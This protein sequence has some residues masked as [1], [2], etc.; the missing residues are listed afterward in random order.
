MYASD[1]PHGEGWFPESATT[2]LG[3]NMPP[4]RKRKLFWD[5]EVRFYALCGLA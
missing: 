5:N 3:W 1:Y 2:V 4:G